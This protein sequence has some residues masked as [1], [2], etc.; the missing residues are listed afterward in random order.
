MAVRVLLADDH[1]VVLEG[2]R[3]LLEGAGDMEIVAA[4]GS[5][6]EAVEAAS[7]LAPDVAVLDVSM[8]AVNG[9]SAART[10]CLQSPKTRVLGLSMHAD[11]QLVEDMLAAGAMG[12][13]IKSAPVEQ[14]LD[15]V[16]KLAAGQ[17]YLS[18]EVDKL[19][20]RSTGRGGGRGG[21][22]RRETEVLQLVAEGKSSKEIA[23]ALHVAT[24]TVDWHRQSIMDKLSIR[25][26]AGLTK[27]A[28]R[29]G[30]T[31]LDPQ[32]RLD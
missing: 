2:L 3:A 22:S 26:I 10:I 6:A 28:I 23:S 18:P 8:P 20:G 9:I 29:C 14:V 7:T 24:K 1:E 5:G 15:A 27:Y 25:S 17:Q 31:T 32:P 11:R 13:V 4:V 16:R 19:I 12:Y 21:L 30:L